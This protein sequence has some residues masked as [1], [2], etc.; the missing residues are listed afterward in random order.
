M[1][2][3]WNAL[4]GQC[5]PKSPHVCASGLDSSEALA[6]GAPLP[7]SLSEPETTWL[8]GGLAT[9]TQH[10]TL[11]WGTYSI[12][13]NAATPGEGV[14]QQM[15][16]GRAGIASLSKTTNGRQA[17]R[18]TTSRVLLG[19]LEEREEEAERDSD[20]RWCACSGE[21]M[22]RV[23]LHTRFEGGI[24]A[25][26]RKSGCN[27]HCGF[28]ERTCSGQF[29]NQERPGPGHPPLPTPPPNVLGNSPGS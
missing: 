15:F 13:I 1:G 3:H 17:L 20:G 19:K 23:P 24:M 18:S 4:R 22:V 14:I 26:S 8:T 29:H 6:P 28:S 12:F 5:T 27:C 16:N 9:C 25:A 10:S 2:S 11:S 7:L 21:G